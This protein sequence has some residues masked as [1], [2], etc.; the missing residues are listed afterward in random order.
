M[1]F[2][3]YLTFFGFFITTFCL[4]IGNNNRLHFLLKAITFISFLF[5]LTFINFNIFYTDLYAQSNRIRLIFDRVVDAEIII[6]L[7]WF[8]LF[9]LLVCIK[10]KVS[11]EESLNI[12]SSLKINNKYR[13][14][15]AFLGFLFSSL[16][17]SIII[18]L[19]TRM[20][21]I[22]LFIVSLTARCIFCV[23][24][25]KVINIK[26]VIIYFSGILIISISANILLPSNVDKERSDTIQTIKSI[27]DTN[28]SSNQ[29]R[30]SFWNASLKMFKEH[31]F[32]GIG[33]G[34]WA[35]LYP[36]YSGDTYTDETV[37]MNFAINPHNDYLEILTEYGIF[38]FLIFTGFI[39]T[40]LYFL[41]KKSRKEIIYLPFLLSALGLCITMFF[42]FT[43]DNFFAMLIF[44]ICHGVGFSGYFEYKIRFSRLFKK[45]LLTIGLIILCTGIALKVIV[46][47]NE[48][49][50][51]DAMQLKAQGKYNQ[52]LDKLE[53]VSGFF[54]PVDMNKMPVDYYRGVGYFELKQYDIALGKFISARKY[55]KYYPTIMNNE[56]SALYMTGNYKEAE[57]RYLEIKKIFPNYIEPQINL[58]AMYAN[59]KQDK[60]A[61]EI[62]NDL[63]C[64]FIN[65]IY[66]K[67]YSV[68]LEIKNYF[69][70]TLY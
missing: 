47:L 58:L 15:I 22:A 7:I 37:D 17:F 68:F 13:N 33:N 63:D 41:F 23:Y 43:K 2:L 20:S 62:I 25:L 60:E 69:K 67:N 24:Y 32:T 54:Y 34:K 26:K 46:Y 27:F 21:W 44:S 66:V 18:Y 1:I 55:S 49:V 65:T 52:M 38:G 11:D 3:K 14:L 35:G 19:K 48:K 10:P 5:T 12:C 16:L 51:L 39:F 29:A 4:L 45:V 8:A 40:G 61:M 9:A 6:S 59:Q 31:P 56:A 42:S 57:Q 64:K 36:V 50:Y 70:V 28:F 30:F 53:E